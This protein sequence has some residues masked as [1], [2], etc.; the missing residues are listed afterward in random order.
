M[1][2]SWSP[3]TAA[4]LPSNEAMTFAADWDEAQPWCNFV[5]TRPKELP[6]GLELERQD[7]RPEV[8]PDPTSGDLMN[9]ATWGQR[10]SYRCVYSGDGRRIRMRQFLYDWAPPAYDHPSLW[11]SE[12]ITPFEAGDNIGWIGRNYRKEPAASI[13]VDRTTIEISSLAGEFMPDEL[14]RLCLGL[15]PVSPTARERILATS[16]GALTFQY[17]HAALTYY[18]TPTGYWKHYRTP[19]SLEQTVAC[20]KDVQNHWPGLDL[21]PPSAYDFGLDTVF[22]FG[23]PRRPREVEYLYESTVTPGRYLRILATS[24]TAECIPYPPIMDQQACSTRQFKVGKSL[25]YHAF[26]DPR[27]GQHEAVLERAGTRFIVMA[28]PGPRTHIEWFE[29]LIHCLY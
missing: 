18:E 13:S 8:P 5:L 11:L 28:K 6:R 26:H 17:R 3:R 16:F 15:E 10:S 21:V 1:V 12:A 14:Q 27:Y 22:V 29:R 9:Q 25:A 7:L 20:G 19:V 23:D 2:E 4:K 24:S